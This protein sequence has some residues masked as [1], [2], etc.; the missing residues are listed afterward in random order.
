MFA[1]TLSGSTSAKAPGGTAG[2]GPPIFEILPED[3]CV[4]TPSP[5]IEVDFLF[6]AGGA[7][8]PGK[9]PG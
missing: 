4:I 3:L 9:C 5:G 7:S 2:G 8:A 6:S 1:G